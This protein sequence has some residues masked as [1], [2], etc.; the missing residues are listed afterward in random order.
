VSEAPRE[1][2]SPENARG[3]VA[4]MARNHVASN[5]L[6]AL[7][8]L[9][10]FA[11]LLTRMNFEVFPEVDIDT[12]L[13]NVV[14]PGASPTEI[15]Q[16]VVLAVEEVVRGLDGVKEVR[17]TAVEG[18]AI[19]AVDLLLGTDQDRALNDVKSAVDR[20]TSFPAEAER[21]VI[22]LVN[23]RNEV[24][25]LIFYG[26][27][28]EASLRKLA[29]RARGE[30]A[31][32]PNITLTELTGVR[33]L[34]VSVQITQEKLR[35]HGLT[36]EEVSAAIRSAN[37]DLPGGEV[38]T[39]AGQI[40]LRTQ[41]RKDF[42]REFGEVAIR[43]RP[44]GSVLRVRDVAT[45]V[46]GF[47]EEDYR[48]EF[49]GK[50]A[51]MVRVFRVGSE[52]PTEVSD[53]VHAYLKEI[54]EELPEGIQ[55]A[56][57]IDW[58][59]MYRD[60]ID[61]LRR[62][63]MLGLLLV[64]VILGLFLEPRLAF[65]VTLGIP[66]SFA[67]SL[68]FLPAA[69]VTINMIS[70]FGFIV[71]LG[72]VV[73]DAIVVGESIYSHRLKGEPLLHSAIAGARDVAVPVTFSIM[74]T[75]VAFA[76]LLFVPGVMGKFFRVVPIVVISVLLISLVESLFVLPA[77]L[78]H[79][80]PRPLE[81]ILYP[82][83]KLLG[84]MGEEKVSRG[85]ERFVE[86]IYKPFLAK[87]LELRYLTLTAGVALLVIAAGIVAGGRVEFTFFPKIEGDVVVARIR[88]P[89]GTP[90]ETTE[91]HHARLIESAQELLD[92]L[93]GEDGGISRGIRSELGASATFDSNAERD[94]GN[95]GSHHSTVM[96]YLVPSDLRDITTS[97]FARRWRARV[98]EVPGAETL[99]FDFNVGA[100]PGRPIDLRLSHAD[101]TILDQAAEDLAKRMERFSGVFDIDSG[102]ATG[103]RQFDLDLTPLGR[104]H[105]LTE[106]MLAQQIRGAFFG[107]ESVRQQRGRDEIRVYVRRPL[108]ERMS[109][110]DIR[111]FVV[112]TPGGGEIPL[113]EAANIAPGR[114]YTAIRRIDGQRA[115]SVTADII[116]GEA[117]AN[118]VVASVVESDLPPLMEKYP[119]LTYAMG[120]A[121]KQQKE[122]LAAL[123][124]GFILA[125][126]TIYGLLAIVFRR[127]LQPI[128]IMSAIPFGLVGAV[129]GHMLMGF[130]LSLMSMM[131][132]VALSGVVVNDS[133]VL[134]DYVN[135]T[136]EKGN[137]AWDSVMAGATRRF[138]P[139]LLTS[140]TTF[141]GLAPMII[142]TSVQARFLI[143]MALS[144]G[145]G[146]LFA[147]AIILVFVPAGYLALEDFHS[148][149][150]F[151]GSPDPG[152][153]MPD[154]DEPAPAGS[155]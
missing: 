70:V 53:E 55:V 112:R 96:V 64:L 111:S 86:K 106:T 123:G 137:S 14:Y 140:L 25:T 73:D 146:V 136:R 76:P 108:E 36:L 119:R 1:P 21:P 128:L 147:T 9:G 78:S 69:D 144:L 17:S 100:N 91:A 72:M 57:W 88:M 34:E 141:F 129:G 61:L 8:I 19:I 41:E 102:V 47:R 5:V 93:S 114:A 35:S 52:S 44:D 16:G 54:R 58:S 85:L 133:L 131:G 83:V 59:D 104:A 115:V 2:S 139:I 63:A 94:A 71:T 80:M 130:D 92:E 3:P 31:A 142:E 135:R 6:M 118:E 117:N 24:V 32:R 62:N 27:A 138:R 37:I 132:L 125:L 74:T 45:V 40:L 56:T 68:L 155:P 109:L 153:R 13:V 107:L 10:G 110:G 66:I 143:P 15:E 103:K 43:A 65:W 51:A 29:E 75:C 95:R 23:N 30:L 67:G 81:I 126:F 84:W 151:F 116:E 82:F 121:Q 50:P 7:L 152:A 113:V 20:I 46:D 12:V 77:H 89:I 18:A 120:G 127:Y 97:E 42:G 134:I 60:R 39:S 49:N 148:K 99:S 22:S 11:S 145:F 154:V 33:P 87:A 26:D 149:L 48:A 79:K 90:I 105:G 98:G 122:S 4:W 101:T 38:K 150:G 28:D 124:G